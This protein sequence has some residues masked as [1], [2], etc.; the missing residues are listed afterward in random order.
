[1][2]RLNM[3]L[4]ALFALV[5]VAA[6]Q[7]GRKYESVPPHSA[8][9]RA[10]EEVARMPDTDV[11]HA[12]TVDVP[13]FANA[14]FE[15]MYHTIRRA[16]PEKRFDYAT[17]IA[18]MPDAPARSAALRSFYKMFIQLDPVGAVDSIDRLHDKRLAMAA[19]DVCIPAAPPV[20]LPGLARLIA[21]MPEDV[22]EEYDYSDD[23]LRFVI[24][25]WSGV[26]PVAASQFLADYRGFYRG[27]YAECLVRNWAALDPESAR[28]WM[29]QG[30]QEAEHDTEDRGAPADFETAWV[31][32]L[33]ENDRRAALD[34]IARNQGFVSDRAVE[35]VA[36]TMFLE[37]ADSARA[38]ADELTM[39]QAKAFALDGVASAADR[40]KYN[41]GADAKRSPE[42]VANWL[43]Q[44]PPEA[45]T[46]AI[47]RVLQTWSW[48]E[49][50][51][52]LAW[53]SGLPADI[54]YAVAAAYPS[55]VAK[56]VEEQ[57]RLIAALP[58]PRLRDTIF[59]RVMPQLKYERTKALAALERVALPPE[60]KSRVAK[61]IPED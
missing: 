21:S 5:L 39:M 36:Y 13:V 9:S 31:R 44:F 7:A 33:F 57:I 28:E 15:Q 14:T 16:T 49:A 38:F 6:F 55:P 45:R 50:Q 23:L 47:E 27:H 35:T 1:M 53:I 58:D 46:R 32:G 42:F 30:W 48:M 4:G 43:L 17:R 37:S 3:I 20:A 12:D 25:K 18:A 60:Q 40:W 59:Q 61:L 41:D 22:I 8:S 51:Q 29:E 2:T 24:I 52:P 56:D 19:I 54:R 34:F 10:P 26:D 11:P